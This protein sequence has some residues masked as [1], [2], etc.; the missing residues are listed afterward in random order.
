MVKRIAGPAEVAPP[1]SRG[2]AAL[3]ELLDQLG[4]AE[5]ARRIGASRATCSA[6]ARGEK[7]P[8]PDARALLAKHCGIPATAWSEVPA[9]EASTRAPRKTKTVSLPPQEKS[10]A[11]RR[12]SRTRPQ[13]LDDLD[14]L[15]AKV[16]AVADDER[17]LP[18]TKLRAL[19]ELR[20]LARL[21]ESILAARRKAES[22]D[23]ALFVRMSPRWRRLQDAY[24]NAL[25][26]HLAPVMRAHPDVRAGVR[27]FC[28]AMS[29]LDLT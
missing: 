10:S 15:E 11:G 19:S 27:R 9:A 2:E 8:G 29:K 4:P 5:V 17:A 16:R 7:H 3:R 25:E 22:D 24:V 14:Q 21:R 13:T 26:Q 6:W 20:Q 28:E 12:L 23:E 18:E 1:R